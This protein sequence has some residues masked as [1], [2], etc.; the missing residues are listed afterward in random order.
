MRRGRRRRSILIDDSVRLLAG[1]A[2]EAAIEDAG[3][4]SLKG[5]D[6]PVRAWSVRWTA[7]RAADVPPAPALAVDA[8]LRA[9]RPRASSSPT[10][11]AAWASACAG[12]PARDLHCGRA[13]HRQDAARRRARRRAVRRRRRPLRPLRRRARSA[14]APV[15]RGAL[16]AYAAAC[17][18]DELRVQLGGGGAHLLGLVPAL[19]ARVAGLVR[20]RA[21]RSGPRAAARPRC[22]RRI[23]SRPPRALA[24]VLLVLDDLHWADELSLHAAAPRPS[25]RRSRCGCSSSRTYRDTEPPRSPLLDEIVTGLAR[26]PEI[27]RIEL[28][29]L[30]E[31]EVAAILARRRPDRARWPATS[32][33]PRRATRSSSARSSGRSPRTATPARTDHAACARRRALAA[34]PPAARDGRA[35]RRGR[36]DRSPSSTSTSSP[37]RAASTSTRDARTRSKPPSARVLS[38]P[39]APSTASRSRTRSYGRRSLATS[40]QGAACALHARVARALELAAARGPSPRGGPGDALRGRGRASSTPPMRCA[41]RVAAGDTAAARSR[42]TSP[43]STTS[44]PCA[45][46]ARMPE[47]TVER[48]TRPRGGRGRALGSAGDE[49]AGRRPAPGCRAAPRPRATA[50]AWREA[51][52]A[53]G[54]DLAT[55]FLVRR[56]ARWSRS[57]AARSSFSPR[58]ATLGPCAAARLPR[59]RGSERHGRGGAAG[60]G[61]KRARP[62]AWRRRSGRARVGADVALLG[63]DGTGVPSASTRTRGRAGRL[64]RC[65]ASV[66]GLGRLRLPLHRAGRGRRRRRGGCRVG[67]RTADGTSPGRPLDRQRVAGHAAAVRRPARRGRAG[68]PQRRRA[69]PGRG[70]PGERRRGHVRIG[71]VVHSRAH[72]RTAGA[73]KP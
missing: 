37:P 61:G 59:R 54:L 15:R 53:I 56:H 52:L 4:L 65:R 51:L 34:E 12:A 63:H 27:E 45:A 16:G 55:D 60:A 30:A 5:I 64:R 47:A 72:G 44:R 18:P 8:A 11:D 7:R 73:R 2:L 58:R 68:G 49:R 22:R 71:D 38:V 9:R 36:G 66:R 24:P 23:C 13:R 41:T 57:C 33:T 48:A 6:A 69:R 62:G 31:S 43:P 46:L 17:P 67:R 21:V 20:A 10:L 1:S 70:V 3:E 40:R 19:A 14:R 25:P 42:S 35:A 32:A 50:I 29:P 28:G 39:R 26:R